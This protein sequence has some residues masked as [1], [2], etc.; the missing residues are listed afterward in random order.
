MLEVGVLLAGVGV[1][2]AML[3]SGLSPF[4]PIKALTVAVGTC[5]V[6]LALALDPQ[7][8][9]AVGRRL[10]RVRAS[11]AWALFLIVG[12][13]ATITSLNPEQSLVGHYAEYQGLLLVIA[14][15]I[16]GFGAAA[17]ASDAGAWTRLR[18]SLA[19]AV[20][21]VSGLALFQLFQGPGLDLSRSTSTLG[22]ASNLG[23]YLCL[24]A[25]L[26]LSGARSERDR[27]WSVVSWA[28]FSLAA[29]LLA[30]TL[31]RGAWVGVAFG[32]MAWLA[33]EGRS[34][35]TKTRVTWVALVAV[36]LIVVL[37]VTLVFVP[38]AG[39]RTLEVLRDPSKGNLGWRLEVWRITGGL[40][41]ARPFLGF[42]PASFRYAFPPTRTAVTLVG[43]TSTQIV[44]DPHNLALSIGVQYGV[45]GLALFLW[46]V[47]GIVLAL[48]RRSSD[49]DPDHSS[50]ALVAALV[51]GV[52]ALQAHFLTLDTWPLLGLV[53][54]WALGLASV[55]SAFAQAQA[56]VG[57]ENRG[58]AAVTVRLGF[59]VVSLAFL[60]VA[61]CA[62]GLVAADGQTIAGIRLAQHKAPWAQVRVPLKQAAALSWWEPTAQLT[63]AR[64]ATQS[65]NTSF[66]SAALA[67]GE[68]AFAELASR[69]PS[70]PMVPAQAAE[71]YV[72]AGLRSGDAALTRKGLELA[73]T[74]TQVDPQ[75]G[76][77]WETVGSAFFALGEVQPA[78][79]AYERAVKL[80]PRDAQAW[81][82]LA[83]VYERL[84][85]SAEATRARAWA[86]KAAKLPVVRFQ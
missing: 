72:I 30:L 26:L 33:V 63:I 40:I 15:T 83:N 77:R 17:L 54:G 52:V 45:V 73:R 69:L 6:A 51:A 81:R 78:R 24:V 7:R 14:S 12:V 20:I 74:A 49:G 65:L 75:N 56:P 16:V 76:F 53:M 11:L 19:A 35:P 62:V 38:H 37:A 36:A 10:G 32:A 41:G 44:D 66:D 79:Q 21:A 84:G 8:V 9:L 47:V 55:S 34:W 39:Q 3:P 18:R 50:A 22:N 61:A 25:P 80:D 68:Q 60:F 67:D 2:L 23:V 13:L 43:Q 4:G 46:L 64:A 85:R 31:S 29:V 28:A 5:V 86:V 42:G 57:A 27:T 71:L 82:N 58:A 1:S 59:A 70:D 48:W